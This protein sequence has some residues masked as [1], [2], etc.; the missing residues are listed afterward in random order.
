[1]ESGNEDILMD[2]EEI[3]EYQE[4][5]RIDLLC[6]FKWTLGSQ[7]EEE[8]GYGVFLKANEVEE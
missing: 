7:K 6:G 4:L 8:G 3:L 2:E 1:V 5:S